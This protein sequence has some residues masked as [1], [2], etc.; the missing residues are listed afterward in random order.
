[1]K[2]KAES[3]FPTYIEQVPEKEGH[4]PSWETIESLTSGYQNSWSKYF[5]LEIV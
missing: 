5:Q 4:T 2:R 1:M 3:V